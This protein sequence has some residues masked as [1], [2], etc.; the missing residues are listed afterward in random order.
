MAEPTRDHTF[1]K[2]CASFSSPDGHNRVTC[3][4]KLLNLEQKLEEQEGKLRMLSL[5]QQELERR[6]GNMKL[7]SKNW[8]GT[9]GNKS[10]S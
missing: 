5:K 10:N 4:Q 1:P 7:R 9:L 8:R 6:T 3:H 2:E